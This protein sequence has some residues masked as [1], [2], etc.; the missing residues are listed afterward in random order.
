MEKISDLKGYADSSTSSSSACFA[1]SD[2]LELFL[3]NFNIFD[4]LVVLFDS[5]NF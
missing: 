4:V 2:V 3:I 1:V 5:I